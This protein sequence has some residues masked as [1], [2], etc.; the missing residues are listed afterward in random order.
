MEIIRE[1]LESFIEGDKVCRCCKVIFAPNGWN[2]YSLCNDCFPIWDSVRV[3][4]PPIDSYTHITPGKGY[5]SSC[6][7]WIK[8]G[9]PKKPEE[10][11][12]VH[13]KD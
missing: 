10:P 2:F 6:D 4:T 13:W 8:D 11:Y 12:K 3:H 7:Q 1:I 9:C 5:Y